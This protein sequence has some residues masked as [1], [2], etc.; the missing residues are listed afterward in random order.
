MI[1]LYHFFH[2]VVLSQPPRNSK[3]EIT[4][5][6]LW[7]RPLGAWTHRPPP[8]SRETARPKSTA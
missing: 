4:T 2:I 1:C 3:E 5:A 8:A 7:A 6:A